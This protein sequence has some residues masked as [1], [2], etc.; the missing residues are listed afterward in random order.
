[1]DLWRR[2]WYVLNR[3]RFDR[4]LAN[5]LEVHRELAARAGSP[6]PFVSAL[7]LREESRD[8]WGWTWIDRTLQDLRYAA[9]ILRKSPGF[10]ATAVVMLAIGIGVNVAAFG[11][12]NLMFLRVLPVR[13]PDSILRLLRRS[14]EGYSTEVAYPA[15]MFYRDHT[16]TLSAVMAVHFERL[17]LDSEAQPLRAQFVTANFFDELGGTATIGRTLDSA[18]DDRPGGVP[19]IVL[20]S[21]WWQRQFGGDP[22]ILGRTLRL[23]G[24]PATVIGVASSGFS[25]LHPDQPDVWLPIVQQP[26]FISGS[27]LLTDFSGTHDGVNM[28]GRLRPGTTQRL[29]EDDLSGLAA[30]LR[31]QQPAAA[32]E[33][34]RFVGQP[35]AYGT[36]TRS[37]ASKG[38]GELPNFRAKQYT[39]AMMVEVLA[40]L[41]LIATCGNLGSLLLARGVGRQ[42]EMTIRAAVGAGSRRLIRQLFTESLLLA[43][44]GALAGFALGYAVLRGLITWTGAP[45]WID[46]TPDWR[47]AIFAAAAGCVAA[48]L[49]GLTPALQVARRR[50]HAGR[51]RTVLIGAQVAASCVLLVVAALLTRAVNRMMFT[52]PGFD[53]EHVLTITP[54]LAGH[55]YAAA[56]ARAYLATLQARVRALPGVEAVS[57][58]LVAPLG[59]SQIVSDMAIA[60]RRIPMHVNRVDPTFFDTMRIPIVRGRTIAPGDTNAIVISVS[61]AMRAWPHD[62]PLGKTMTLDEDDSGAPR[63]YTVVGIAGNAR[64]AALDNPD[65]VEIY[66]P[67]N[68][69]DLPSMHVI[70]RSSTATDALVPA[71]TAITQS[72]DRDVFSQI[73]ILKNAFGRKVE[74]AERGALA[75]S[76]LGVSALLLA[77]VGIVG[78]VAYA[79]SQRTKEI[80]IRIALGAARSQVIFVVLH[81]FSRPV[82]VGM[83]VGVAGAAALSQ[84]LRGQLYGIS[85][86]D[87]LAYAAAVAMFI[88]SIGVAALFPSMRALR[89]D[90]LRALR[91]E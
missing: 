66:F 70:V 84:L 17:S 8:A 88:F 11:F 6:A 24:K 49:F 41:I 23:N 68:A 90:P 71:V 72:L 60:D 55:G 10:T 61:A 21:G 74:S 48:M 15:M 31:Q 29:A 22:A 69:D 4:E 65:A 7:T 28:W 78:L 80:G 57:I 34:E 45:P 50:P 53:Y 79:V 51:T 81:Q 87:P 86:L 30:L 77:C 12:F 13:D 26:Y 27:Q 73:N 36:G 91:H 44:L 1:M 52:S 76:L 82:A 47:V 62:D 43:A 40:L 25:G 46:P 19:R 9:R 54:D 89:I 56:R 38:S 58:A 67:V 35:G 5:D 2:L 37:G 3:H 75:V 18:I 33:H 59:G 16:R 64:V 39:A 85:G 20:S 32:W 14:P 63:P 83:L 42:R